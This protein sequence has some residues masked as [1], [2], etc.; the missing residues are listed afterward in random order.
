MRKLGSGMF[1]A[2]FA[3]MFFAG[4]GKGLFPETGGGIESAVRE[5]AAQAGGTAGRE[6]DRMKNLTAQ[7]VA[8]EMKLGWNLGNTL[9]CTSATLLK[10]SRP[11]KWETAWGNPVTTQELIRKVTEAGFNV[12]RIPVSW[13]DHILVSEDYQIEESWMERVREVVDYAYRQGVYV[14]VNAHHESWYDPYYDR[15]ERA[16]AMMEAVWRQIADCFA[17]YD[18]HLIFEGMN[19]PRKVGTPQ[20]WTGGDEEGW[21]VVNRLNRVF[22]E[23]VRAG[24]GNNPD[25]ILMIPGYG[26]NAGKAL[27]HLE[28]PEDS[29]LIVSVHAYEPYDFALNVQGRGQWNED[30]DEIDAVMKRIDELFVSKG[31]PVVI[32]E[33]GA[34]SKPADGNEEER[35]AWARYYTAAARKIGVPCIWWDN[36][37]LEGE[38]E[39]F[40][41]LDRTTYEWRYPLVLEGLREGSAGN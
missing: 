37:V 2:V 32:G 38:G 1:L 35:A 24:K 22:V 21:A 25:R 8:A 20:E 26:A 13:N 9:D 31:I 11:E 27:F 15:E 19:E 3:L 29:R 10:T 6:K 18:E 33:F 30:T 28:V 16:A 23:T 7:A 4:C 39:S 40:G 17:E 36:G 5:T 34:M 41:L 12:I 14:I